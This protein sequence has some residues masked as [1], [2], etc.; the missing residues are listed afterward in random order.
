MFTVIFLPPVPCNPGHHVPSDEVDTH[1]HAQFSECAFCSYPI[2]RSVYQAGNGL[3]TPYSRWL[4]SA[5]VEEA[6]AMGA[7]T[8]AGIVLEL[9]RVEASAIR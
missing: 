1:D 4:T 5:E 3:V 7:A 2:A 6:A 9:V 8:I